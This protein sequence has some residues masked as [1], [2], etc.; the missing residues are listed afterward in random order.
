VVLKRV[1]IE[2]LS[3]ESNQRFKARLEVDV[4]DVNV[5]TTAT[6]T[7]QQAYKPT[8]THTQTLGGEGETTGEGGLNGEGASSAAPTRLVVAEVKSPFQAM[9]LAFRYDAKFVCVSSLLENGDV[10]MELNE[11]RGRFPELLE[12][13]PGGMKQSKANQQVEGRVAL[14]LD[15]EYEITRLERQLQTA[16]E[17]GNEAAVVKLRK[18]LAIYSRDLREVAGGGG[19]VVAGQ[20]ALPTTPSF[21]EQ[22]AAGMASQ[23]Q[24]QQQQQVYQQQQYQQQQQQQQQYQQQQQQGG[25]HEQQPQQQHM[26]PPYIPPPPADLIDSP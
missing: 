13:K 21:Y 14:D 9:A 7:Q 26:A 2:Q 23:A 10:S 25:G 24:A 18:Q 4:G 15:S 1:V 3:G 11:V 20:P 17:E 6:V 22:A 19:G 8:P 12:L 5:T 16:L